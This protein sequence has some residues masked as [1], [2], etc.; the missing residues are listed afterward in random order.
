MNTTNKMVQNTEQPETIS[1]G[2][3][4]APPV[5]VYENAD[6]ILMLVDV[7][8]VDEAG[9]SLRLEGGQLDLEARQAVQEHDGFQPVVFARSFTL[10]RTIDS[11]GVSANLTQGVLT[12]RLRKSEAA[13][14]RRIEIKAS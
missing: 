7:P 10:P 1:Q 14:P 13:K 4:V 8:G 3:R 9:L 6:E 2:V 11:E 12:V 5:D